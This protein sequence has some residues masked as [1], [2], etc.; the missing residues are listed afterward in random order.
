MH[1]KCF[2]QA[3][4]RHLLLRDKGQDEHSE[5]RM[6]V[7]TY[8]SQAH[9]R[10]LPRPMLRSALRIASPAAASSGFDFSARNSMKGR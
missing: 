3:P 7:D 10:Y 9:T 8:A 4:P 2:V 1:A 5:F 6:R